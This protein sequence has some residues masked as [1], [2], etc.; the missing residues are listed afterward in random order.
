MG[1]GVG[2]A[3]VVWLAQGLH[4]VVVVAVAAFGQGDDVVDLVGEAVA[5]GVFAAGVGALVGVHGVGHA[6]VVVAAG[7]G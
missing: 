7:V 6:S 5:A 4:V 1:V 2:L 3:V